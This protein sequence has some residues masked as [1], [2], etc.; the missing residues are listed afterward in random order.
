MFLRLQQKFTNFVFFWHFCCF[1]LYV[2]RSFL[3]K[4]GRKK[5]RVKHVVENALDI[6]IQH[7]HS[8]AMSSHFHIISPCLEEFHLMKYV[9][10]KTQHNRKPTLL[11]LLRLNNWL[12]C[13]A[14]HFLNWPTFL[15]DEL[16]K[17][18]KFLWANRRI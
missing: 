17:K 2:I 3:S 8:L 13:Y 18:K 1:L 12:T 6:I 16:H 9:Y 7:Y 14:S 11:E 15:S 4:E 10:L 5:L